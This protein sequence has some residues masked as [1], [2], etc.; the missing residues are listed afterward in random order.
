MSF[1]G[2][3]MSKYESE[4][5]PG[6]GSYD[7]AGYFGNT[8]G[9]VTTGVLPKWRHKLRTTW[10]TPWKTDL[11]LTWRYLSAVK[12]ETQSSNPLLSGTVDPV[13][14]KFPSFNYFD[15]SAKYD[16]S[17]NLAIRF[18]INNLF[19]KDPPLAVTGAPYGNGN[20]YPVMY[21][22]LGRRISLNL[23]ASF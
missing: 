16:L 5:V 23:T 19:D 18:A 21:D 13:M 1:I 3:L 12:H 11:T 20:T 7:C 14:A 17:K 22:A 6:D 9:T 4:P 10:N 15:I 2:T 8:C